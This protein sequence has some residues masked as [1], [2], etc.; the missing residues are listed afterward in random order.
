MQSISRRTVVVATGWTA[1]G[2]AVAITAPAA[3][4]SSPRPQEPLSS[5]YA[6]RLLTPPTAVPGSDFTSGV[7]VIRDGSGG[8]PAAVGSAVVTIVGGSAHFAAG[9][10]RLVSTSSQVAVAITAGV[11]ALPRLIPDGNGTIELAVQLLIPDGAVD[12]VDDRL[13]RLHAGTEPTVYAIDPAGV[14]PNPLAPDRL[15]AGFSPFY[16]LAGW[17][18]SVSTVIAPGWIGSDERSYAAGATSPEETSAAALTVVSAEGEPLL[19]ATFRS[20]YVVDV[21][22]DVYTAAGT[23]FNEPP[24]S[25]QYGT[26]PDAAGDGRVTTT[27]HPLP[28]Q[29]ANV[30]ITPLSMLA[31]DGTVMV[32]DNESYGFIPLGIRGI[33]DIFGVRACTFGTDATR[34]LVWAPDAGGVDADYG[35]GAEP[36]GYGVAVG[37][38]R[39]IPPAA[40]VLALDAGQE[41]PVLAVGADGEVWGWGGTHFLPDALGAYPELLDLLPRDHTAPDG[42]YVRADGSIVRL[43]SSADTP[44]VALDTV[45]SPTTSIDAQADI[46]RLN[47][48]SSV[49]LL[50]DGTAHLLVADGSATP[51]AASERFLRI[52]PFGGDLLAVATDQRLRLVSIDGTG[53]L[54]QEIEHSGTVVQLGDGIV[55]LSGTA[56]Q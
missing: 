15:V 35:V 46:V 49:A 54:V 39:P 33:R 32:Y 55:E 48:P 8:A 17:V 47:A 18:A 16:S 50:P 43:R 4:A 56:D 31:A 13:W 37:G 44:H 41:Y 12:L 51:I 22:G 20:G 7:G 23:G 1:P 52:A 21:N 53:A 38:S 25:E 5:R 40:V 10:E 14:V 11:F 26:D 27:M 29:R 19:G 45:A 3:A 2:I 9:N 36:L 28:V 6:L 42:F 34:T 24:P 30:T